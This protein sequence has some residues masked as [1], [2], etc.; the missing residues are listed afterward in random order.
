MIIDNGSSRKPICSYRPL[1]RYDLRRVAVNA[2]LK[3]WLMTNIINYCKPLFYLHAFFFN[4]AFTLKP[5]FLSSNLKQA[6][7]HTHTLPGDR[8]PRDGAGRQYV[9]E[10][11]N[12]RNNC[13]VLSQNRGSGIRADDFGGVAHASAALRVPYTAA[14]RSR[15]VSWR[16]VTCRNTTLRRVHHWTWLISRGG[17]RETFKH[18]IE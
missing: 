12:V 11:K 10:G 9:I 17:Q 16:V 8:F 18:L 1:A 5:D 6:H 7:T 3:Q 14:R 13:H 15:N 4:Y 2:P